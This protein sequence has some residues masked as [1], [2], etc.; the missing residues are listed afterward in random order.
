MIAP[1]RI[2]VQLR[3][4]PHRRLHAPHVSIRSVPS[5]RTEHAARP[6]PW[7]GC[8]AF[9]SDGRCPAARNGMS[10][11]LALSFRAPAWTVHSPL[12]SGRVR[13]SRRDRPGSSDR[14]G[15]AHVDFVQ[16][17]ACAFRGARSFAL[18]SVGLSRLQPGAHLVQLVLLQH[19]RQRGVF[20]RSEMMLSA[21]RWAFRSTLRRRPWPCAARPPG[22]KPDPSGAFQ[23]RP[24]GGWSRCGLLPP[25][26]APVPPL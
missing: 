13:I 15:I 19:W 14:T 6:C 25:A 23:P 16:R 26:C 8:R 21:S 24:A 7:R 18:A 11:M 1:S 12:A 10:S 5:A 9:R 4:W 3:R 2:H 17:L 22:G 20:L